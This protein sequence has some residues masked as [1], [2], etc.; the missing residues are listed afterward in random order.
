VTCRR[1]IRLISPVQAAESQK[2]RLCATRSDRTMMRISPVSNGYRQ[3]K[4]QSYKPT[5]R[6]LLRSV[7]APLFTD[8]SRPSASH[9]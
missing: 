2:Q 1:I 4:P 8:I 9:W 5:L 6:Y 7:P 3:F